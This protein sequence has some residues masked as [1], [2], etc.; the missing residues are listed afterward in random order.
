M[1]GTRLFFLGLAALLLPGADAVTLTVNGDIAIP[2]ALTPDDLAKM[3]RVTVPVAEPDGST[4]NY[5]G[6]QVHEILK[7]AGAPSGN[8]LQK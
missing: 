7:K 6:V 8:D 4:V 5:E 2:Q 1:I 3:P